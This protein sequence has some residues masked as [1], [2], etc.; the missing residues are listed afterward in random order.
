MKTQMS[1]IKGTATYR[2][3]KNT[4]LRLNDQKIIPTPIFYVAISKCLNSAV[5]CPVFAVPLRY[6]KMERTADY[7]QSLLILKYLCSTLRYLF[8]T[9]PIESNNIYKKEV[10]IYAYIEL[11]VKPT[12]TY[13]KPKKIRRNSA[14]LLSNMLAVPCAFRYRET[15]KYSKSSICS[16]S[17]GRASLHHEAPQA[18]Q[19]AA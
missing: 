4:I 3:A 10:Y 2:R 17:S 6:L 14:L 18:S 19:V 11:L 13:R 1:F 8:S 9:I 12:A 16:K 5:P 7:F 15:Q